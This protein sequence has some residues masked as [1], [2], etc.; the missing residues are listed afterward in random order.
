MIT[1]DQFHM[2]V[3]VGRYALLLGFVLFFSIDTSAQPRREARLLAST[4]PLTDNWLLQSS[5]KLQEPGEV[6]ST[7]GLGS[8]DWYRTKV[9][10]TVLA[11]LVANKLYP[12][13][14]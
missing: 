7:S 13:P 10:S 9:P 11:A 5:T 12:S 3:A 8:K 6:L 4:L 2:N 14:F 1:S